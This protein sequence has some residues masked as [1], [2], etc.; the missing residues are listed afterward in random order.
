MN[1]YSKE[2]LMSL[3]KTPIQKRMI[4]LLIEGKTGEEIIDLLLSDNEG[5]FND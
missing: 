3:A 4:E 2:Y 1:D 5:V